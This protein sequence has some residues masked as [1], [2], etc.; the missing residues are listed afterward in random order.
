[1]KP[2]DLLAPPRL[3]WTMVRRSAARLVPRKMDMAS[4]S[5]AQLARLVES[6]VLHQ[7]RAGTT[8]RFI[9]LMFVTVGDRV[10][11]RRYSFGE[12][13]WQ[14]V[15]KRDPLGQVRLDGVVV[16][17]DAVVPDDLDEVNPAVNDAYVASLRKIGAPFLIAGTMEDRSMAS[18]MEITVR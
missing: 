9:D 14:D 7:I 17:I 11:C 15:F 5:Q 4:P 3:L 12:R 2:S 1:M 13:S 6:T 8:H 18:T 16:D 10:F